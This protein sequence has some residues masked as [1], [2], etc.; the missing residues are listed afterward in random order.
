MGGEGVVQQILRGES[1]SVAPRRSRASAYRGPLKPRDKL[2]KET[3]PGAS[4][5]K[6]RR[7][8][9]ATH[10]GKL[11]PRSKRRVSS[12]SPQKIK[13]PSDKKID[14]RRKSSSRFD[15]A[16]TNKKKSEDIP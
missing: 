16:P 11:K 6:S 9:S 14:R 2:A 12:E 13:P 15:L 3:T 1:V 7:S 5:V 4:R 10:S 8:S